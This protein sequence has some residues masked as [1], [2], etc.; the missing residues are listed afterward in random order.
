[1]SMLADVAAASPFVTEAAKAPSTAALPAMP[2][3]H[4]LAATLLPSLARNASSCLLLLDLGSAGTS[5]LWLA[6]SVGSVLA[7]SLKTPVHV[8]STDPESSREGAASTQARQWRGCV[9]ESFHA[10]TTGPGSL[11]ERLAELRAAGQPVLLHAGRER[12][13]PED[14]LQGGAVDA[15]VLLARAARTRRAALQTAVHRLSLTGVPLL[16]CVLLDRTYPVPEKLYQL[17]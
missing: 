7:D 5:S 12:A 11:P 10:A 4:R 6:S 17:L 2:E 3:V 13:L 1:M 15:V 9:V 14:L 16:G 8:L